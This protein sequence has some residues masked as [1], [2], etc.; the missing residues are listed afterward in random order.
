MSINQS[1]KSHFLKTFWGSLLA[2]G[3]RSLSRLAGQLLLCLR[4]RLEAMFVWKMLFNFCV[5]VSMSHL[6]I[7]KT[8]RAKKTSWKNLLHGKLLG[9]HLWI[10]RAS[11][12]SK[13][14]SMFMI[15]STDLRKRSGHVWCVCLLRVRFISWKIGLDRRRKESKK[16][17]N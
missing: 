15:L 11:N 8:G 9:V 12:K 3:I 16:T 1:R 5:M 7:S 17:S 4:L 10:L 14:L 6:Q 2:P 13:W